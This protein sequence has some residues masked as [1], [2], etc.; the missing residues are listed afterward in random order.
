[1]FMNKN[2]YLFIYLR[3]ENSITKKIKLNIYIYLKDI[4]LFNRTKVRVK[5]YIFTPLTMDIIL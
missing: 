1:M 2:N 4:K 3:V 5:N